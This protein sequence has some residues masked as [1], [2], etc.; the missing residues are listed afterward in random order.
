MPL[1]KFKKKDFG[2]EESRYI[3]FIN[4][5]KNLKL[6]SFIFFI[7]PE[8]DDIKKE[9]KTVQKLECLVDSNLCQV[10]IYIIKKR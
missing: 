3:F 2:L 7:R 9:Q 4:F 1:F 5:K 10:F 6:F 8:T